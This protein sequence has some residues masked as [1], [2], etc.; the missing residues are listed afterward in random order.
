MKLNLRTNPSNLKFRHSLHEQLLDTQ[1]SVDF[2]HDRF[3]K[4]DRIRRVPRE[5]LDSVVSRFRFR[6]NRV[7]CRET[8]RLAQ[9][10][11]KILPATRTPIIVQKRPTIKSTK[12]KTNVDVI[13]VRRSSQDGRSRF[14]YSRPSPVVSWIIFFR[15]RGSHSIKRLLQELVFWL[16]VQ[17]YQ[18]CLLILYNILNLWYKFLCLGII[19]RGM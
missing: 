13:M 3:S 7:S 5:C 18:Q 16:F 6:R 10:P 1:S 9:D 4:L 8:D 17:I 14:S 11:S 12:A 19:W 15:L 2:R